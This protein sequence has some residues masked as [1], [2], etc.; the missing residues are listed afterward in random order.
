MKQTNKQTKRQKIG[1]EVQ[2]FDGS[3]ATYMEKINSYMCELLLLL[4]TAKNHQSY[5]A[6]GAN[7]CISCRTVANLQFVKK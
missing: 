4:K 5:L 2:L 3:E 6:T 7:G 1:I